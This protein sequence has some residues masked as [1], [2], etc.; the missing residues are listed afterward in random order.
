[1]Q[2]GERINPQT[3]PAFPEFAEQ[4]GH[5]AY[6]VTEDT[7]VI[8]SQDALLEQ[9]NQDVRKGLID[10]EEAAELAVELGLIK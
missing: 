7:E 2:N 8:Q 3:D 4:H 9:I 5:F 6:D 10:P 1:M